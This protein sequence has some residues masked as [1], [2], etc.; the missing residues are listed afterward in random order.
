MLK[1][2]NFTSKILK[3]DHSVKKEKYEKRFP[4]LYYVVLNYDKTNYD[5]DRNM[6]ILKYYFVRSY[7]NNIDSISTANFPLF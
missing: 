4:K 3:L 1:K 6:L 5:I 2:K 7:A